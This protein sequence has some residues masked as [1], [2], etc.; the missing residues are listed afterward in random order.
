MV[1]G[2][3][4]RAEGS[5]IAFALEKM[6]YGTFEADWVALDLKKRE[7]LV[8]EGLYRGACSPATDKSRIGCPEATVG[9]LAGVDEYNLIRM[10]N[11]LVEHDLPGT[12]MSIH[13]SSS[14]IHT[15]K[16][17]PSLKAKPIALEPNSMKAYYDIPAKCIPAVKMTKN[18]G[19]GPVRGVQYG[20]F[21]CKQSKGRDD[22]KSCGRCRLVRYC[23]S[24]C[25]K[26]DWKNHK[27]F[28]GVVDFDPALLMPAPEHAL[29][30]IGCPAP[31]E[32]YLRTPALWRQ[33]G[34]LGKPD[35]QLQDYH[36][37]IG[38]E[39]TRSLRVIHPPGAQI[40]FLVARRR[41]MASG[42]PAAV[43]T[44][45]G[46]I[47]LMWRHGMVNLTPEQIRGQFE[48]EYRVEIREVG[49]VIGAGQFEPPT[50]QERDEEMAYMRQ[51]FATATFS[52]GVVDV[53]PFT[54][55]TRRELEEQMAYQEG[56][57]KVGVPHRLPPAR[58]LQE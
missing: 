37:E 2:D 15:S 31:V 3:I 19:A 27:K 45:I 52:E 42:D 1:I 29:E 49:G 13:C 34:Y 41:A 22:L 25:Q 10:L 35:S 55:L 33:I 23:S 9:G 4:M 21:T 48:R 30:F 7:A 44:M 46:I 56:R 18:H 53:G 12:A 5:L 6:V 16:T 38:P 17:Y 51:R 47:Q 11:R 50:Q 8:L 14:P 54:P 43:N 40:I 24:E 32:G 57:F 28:C 58:R 36:F 26:K 20:C 39:R